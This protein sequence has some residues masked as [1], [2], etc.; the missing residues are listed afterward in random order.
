LPPETPATE[1]AGGPLG[2]DLLSNLGNGSNAAMVPTPAPSTPKRIKLGGVV[3]A[4]KIIIQMQP[5]Y[6]ALARQAR[7][8]EMWCCMQCLI[9]MAA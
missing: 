4:A 9:R 6:P 7:I 5:L 1:T 8:Q 2:L 3:Q